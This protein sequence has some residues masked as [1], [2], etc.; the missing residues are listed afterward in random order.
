MKEPGFEFNIK[1]EGLIG[2]IPFSSNRIVV[3][4]TAERGQIAVSNGKAQIKATDIL[5]YSSYSSIE[6]KFGTY[7]EF[8]GQSELTLMRGV[9]LLT[10]AGANWIYPIRIADGNESGGTLRIRK[11]HNVVGAYS[12]EIGSADTGSY[13]RDISIRIRDTD[14]SPFQFSEIFYP[15][16][17]TTGFTLRYYPYTG[18]EQRVVPGSTIQYV[19]GAIWTKVEVTGLI[20]EYGNFVEDGKNADWATGETWT[21]HYGNNALGYGWEHTVEPYLTANLSTGGNHDV[22]IL[23]DTGAPWGNNLLFMDDATVNQAGAPCRKGKA[24]KVTYFYDTKDLEVKWHDKTEVFNGLNNVNHWIT[25]VNSGSTL[26]KLYSDTGTAQKVVVQDSGSS[27]MPINMDWTNL[28]KGNDGR[29]INSNDYRAALELISETSWD[30]L[31]LP[32]CT[33][34]SIH[35]IVKSRLNTDEIN[36]FEHKACLGHDTGSTAGEIISWADEVSDKLINCYTFGENGILMTN[37]YTGKLETGSASYGACIVAANKA[38]RTIST[39]MI[40]VAL[41]GIEGIDGEWSKPQ[42]EIFLD[43]GI[44][45]VMKDAGYR[46]NRDI[47]SSKSSAWLKAT[48]VQIVHYARQGSRQVLRDFKGKKNINRVRKRMEMAADNF[49][50]TMLADEHVTGFKPTEVTSTRGEQISGITRVKSEIQ[51]VYHVEYIKFDLALG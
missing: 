27:T 9:D 36:N 42:R 19:T 43:H 47:T 1:E 45:T 13:S 22:S 24:I 6:E 31:V 44:A 29:A 5:A 51:P 39:D 23:C 40:G 16:G 15:D 11:S 33:N 41:D 12:M 32:G 7:D 8:T 20:D 26:I 35:N 3:I 30:Y 38:K 49:Y 48:T 25:Q 21:V 34:T 17:T 28:N 46:I 14:G 37:R 50:K 4:G 18:N 10:A 2:F